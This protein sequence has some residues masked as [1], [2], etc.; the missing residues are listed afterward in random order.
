MRLA[1]NVTTYS[2]QVTLKT[3]KYREAEHFPQHPS[4]EPVDLAHSTS[5][6]VDA[7]V[8]KANGSRLLHLPIMYCASL[9]PALLQLRPSIIHYVGGTKPHWVLNMSLDDPT[10]TGDMDQITI[11][12]D[13][14]VAWSLHEYRNGTR[15]KWL[16]PRPASRGCC[17][18][19]AIQMCLRTLTE[20]WLILWNHT[21]ARRKLLRKHTHGQL[22]HTSRASSNSVGMPR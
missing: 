3:A 18:D 11:L 15:R 19:D 6:H 4:F 9:G 12:L 20:R 1:A 5:M 14:Y 22:H 7:L 10:F 2:E 21:R 13:R 8:S 16:G 17:T